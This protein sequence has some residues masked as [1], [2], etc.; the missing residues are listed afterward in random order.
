MTEIRTTKTTMWNCICNIFRSV[1]LLTVVIILAV[2]PPMSAHAGMNDHDH[3]MDHSVL[4]SDMDHSA[5][6]VADMDM[7]GSDTHPD[8][9]AEMG[10]CSGICAVTV[11]MSDHCDGYSKQ[12]RKHDAM[13]VLIL[14]SADAK[15]LIRPPNL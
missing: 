11:L 3:K 8:D 10:C 7:S 6:G 9:H 15:R 13:P 14:T 4:H 5:H 12:A 2:S 1:S